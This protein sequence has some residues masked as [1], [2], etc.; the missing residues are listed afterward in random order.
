VDG[1]PRKSYGHGRSLE[2]WEVLLKGHHEGYI[3]WAEFERNRTQLA[4]NTYQPVDKIAVR[5]PT[6]H[7]L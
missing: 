5:R 4:A 3:D 7:I 1:R 2:A 6:Y